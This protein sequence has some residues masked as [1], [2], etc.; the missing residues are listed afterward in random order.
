MTK[1]TEKICTVRKTDEFLLEK[2]NWLTSSEDVMWAGGRHKFRV[3]DHTWHRI[4]L[5]HILNHHQGM[6]GLL[7]NTGREG[8]SS[9]LIFC[10]KFT[11]LKKSSICGMFGFMNGI[12]LL[13]MRLFVDER[14]SV[15]HLQHL[16]FWYLS[17]KLS[18]NPIFSPSHSFPPVTWL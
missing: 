13:L 6:S 12:T 4:E 3:W 17:I 11:A 7:N 16:S 2:E 10:I 5:L 9:S 8:W 14:V 1:Y 18:S 15:F